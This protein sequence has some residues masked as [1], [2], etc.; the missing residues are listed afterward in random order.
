MNGAFYLSR[1]KEL[2]SRKMYICGE[3]VEELV[4]EL[5]EGGGALFAEE[6]GDGG[7]W[8]AFEPAGDEEVVVVHVWVEVEG[9]PVEGDPFADSYSYGA[10]F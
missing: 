7:D 6:L 10:D 5:I 3:V 8:S 4:G 1:E 2:L 9:E